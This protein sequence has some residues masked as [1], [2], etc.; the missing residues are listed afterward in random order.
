MVEIAKWFVFLATFMAWT[1]AEASETYLCRIVPLS[2]S[3][4]VPSQVAMELFDGRKS[5]RVW[6]GSEGVAVPVEL[7]K[8]SENSYLLD[9]TVRPAVLEKMPG[10]AGERFQVILNLQNLKVSVLVLSR[11]EMGTLSPRGVGRCSRIREAEKLSQR[12]F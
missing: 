2:K 8:R 9:W 4:L 1:T 5:A 10:M 7:E 12:D 11:L 3:S 6:D